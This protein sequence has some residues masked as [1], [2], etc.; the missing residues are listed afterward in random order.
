MSDGS[1]MSEQG[2]LLVFVPGLREGKSGQL[3]ERIRSTAEKADR[4]VTYHHRVRP[5]SVRMTP[6]IA[7]DNLR[8]FIDA[9]VQN[10]NP[11]KI[12]LIG[13]SIGG[14]IADPRG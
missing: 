1:V 7:S 14:L 12:T 2:R 8:A 4:V 9:E 5:W 3:V 11:A 13:H 6:E 10:M